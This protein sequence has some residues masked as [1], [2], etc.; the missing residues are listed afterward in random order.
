VGASVGECQSLVS[1]SAGVI[2]QSAVESLA[3]LLLSTRNHISAPVHRL[4]SVSLI[5]CANLKLKTGHTL[6]RS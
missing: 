1:A 5:Y 4:S 3:L 2:R 6:M